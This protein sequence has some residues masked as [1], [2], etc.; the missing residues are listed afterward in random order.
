MGLIGAKTLGASDDALHAPNFPWSH[1]RPWA[2]FDH[3]SMRRG[4][5]VYQTVCATCHSL[6]LVAY[7]NLVGE[8]LT[9]EEAKE[10]AADIDVEDE[11]D[12][13]G[14]INERPG[15]LIDYFPAPYPNEQAA[16][17][18]NNA[19]LPPDLS[20]ITKA[21]PQGENYLFALL[22]GFKEPPAGVSI[23]EGS[24]YNPYFPGG[25][26]GM[27]PPLSNDMV[28]YDD[29]TEASISQMAKDVA[30]FLCWAAEPKHDERKR[31]GIK[32]MFVLGLMV[33]PA[34]YHKRLRW[35]VIKSRQV[36]FI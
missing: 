22:T 6:N 18:A 25:V 36:R 32:T 17:A 13:E 1:R 31:M 5:Q 29:G 3:H 10:M 19:A 21:R 12:A 16:R 30:T 15:K 2:A 4:L 7:R 27:A 34:L 23:R 20:L 11:P 9:E 14:E 33:F 24:Y 35:S 28:E 26:I 8:M